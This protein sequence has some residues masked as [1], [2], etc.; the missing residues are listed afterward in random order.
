MQDQRLATILWRGKW[1]I[2]STVAVG[3]ALAYLATHL[4]SKVYEASATI[5]VNAGG[6]TGANGATPNDIVNAN[7]GLAQTYATLITDRSFLQQIQPHV[8]GGRLTVGDIEGRLS[9]RAVQNTSLVQL[10]ADGPSPRDARSL[11]GAVARNFVSSIGTDS[12]QRTDRLQ[13]QIQRRIQELDR[14]IAAG[15]QAQTL[16]SLRGARAELE[17]QLAALVA[18]QIAQGASVTLIGQ[19]TGSS[20][21]VKPR[22]LLNMIAGVLLGLLAGVGLSYLRVRL[23]RA[24]H[25]AGEAEQLLGVPVLA[26]IPIRR[27]MTKDDPQLGEAF[28]VLRANLAF[29][30]HDQ[31]LHV[32]TLSS[33]NPREGKSSTV[34]GLAYAAVRGGLNVLVID[35]DVR[36]RALSSRLGHADT[37]GLT[38][39][40]VGMANVDDTIVQLT[41]GLSLLPA[42][43]MP[44]NPPSLLSSV[45]MRELIAELRERHGL[46]LIDSPPVAHLADA[47]ILASVSDGVVV[48]A[49]VGV[50][51]RADL[52]AAAANLR[53][54][55]T[56]IIGVVVLEPRTI[57]ETYYPAVTKGT[58]PA[59]PAE[60]AAAE[61]VEL[62]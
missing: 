23:D 43:P 24:L 9:A 45:R 56:P 1:I 8:F 48:V 3:I 35:G 49:R 14:E 34:E 25:S 59:V 52:P 57:D 22:P 4:S 55:P 5:Q 26:P 51:N 39:V 12:V 10:V 20:A 38:N 2:L 62:L 29:L 33:F 53:Q 44:P 7:L 54:V 21:P 60:S 47:S 27:R 32:I 11:A 36:T 17:K 50:T 19:P 28:D 15:G 13:Q 41:P 18:G 30:S 37:P 42:G 6:V 61:P 40:I 58:D 46:I 31:A 16:E